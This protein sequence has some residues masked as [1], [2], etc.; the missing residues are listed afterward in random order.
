MTRFLDL[1]VSTNSMVENP[2]EARDTA[3]LCVECQEPEQDGPSLWSTVLHDGAC[4]GGGWQVCSK[5][6]RQVSTNID[7]KGR[8]THQLVGQ[9]ELD[10]QTLLLTKQPVAPSARGTGSCG[11]QGYSSTQHWHHAHVCRSQGGGS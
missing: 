7:N 8:A 11:P 1:L 10:G 6:T 2:E 3:L 9:P 5:G 4:A